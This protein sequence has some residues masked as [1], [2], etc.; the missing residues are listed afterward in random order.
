[1]GWQ[2]GRA[3]LG[4]GL[5]RPQAVRPRAEGTT[6]Q[7]RK[8]ELDSSKSALTRSIN[9]LLYHFEVCWYQSDPQQSVCR[10][11]RADGSANIQCA[12]RVTV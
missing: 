4:R 11:Q 2:A 1:M 5:G 6:K 3:G 9:W 8:V 10:L 7:G 12:S